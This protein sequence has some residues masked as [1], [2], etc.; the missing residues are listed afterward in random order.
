MLGR[1][2][3]PALAHNSMERSAPQGFAH[4][5][6][7]LDTCRPLLWISGPIIAFSVFQ[8]KTGHYN[9]R[10]KQGEV[11]FMDYFL[12]RASGLLVTQ[13]LKV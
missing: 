9:G 4:T 6:F 5:S 3:P 12:R 11:K 1:R 2:G 8:Q 7:C 13:G 10:S